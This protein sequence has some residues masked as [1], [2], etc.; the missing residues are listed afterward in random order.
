VP[1]FRRRSRALEW[2]DTA[3]PTREERAA[4]LE[5]LAWFNGVMLGHRPVLTWLAKAGRGARGPLTL[6]DVG[7][8]YGDLL[9][10]IRRWANRRGI[11]MRLI[12]VD[13]EPD[14]V[15]IARDAT[16]ASDDIAYL[17]ADVFNLKPAVRVD[18]IVSSLVAH[19]L[20]GER[21]PAFLRWMETT[22]RR[23]WMIADL[24]RH[25]FSYHAIGLVGRLLR[26]H[27]LVVK[28]GQTSVM[29]SLSAQ[30][31][32]PVIAAAGIE[33]QAVQIKWFLYRL[34]VSRLK[35]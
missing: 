15:A 3:S 17:V 30:D 2:L 28:D 12:G 7:C 19:H 5:S 9:R 10:A 31:W 20:D 6:I 14:T 33:P 26:I 25:P 13:I 21:M 23:G 35:D 4:Y 29:R 16:P 1:D 34:A 27:P 22:A 18:L 24:D 11:A 32:R 8:G